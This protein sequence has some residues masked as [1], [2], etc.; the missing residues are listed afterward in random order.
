VARRLGVPFV[1]SDHVTEHRSGCAIREFFARKGEGRFRDVE[2]QV[3]DN[4]SR[5]HQGVIATDGGA[6]LPEANCQH[7]HEQRQVIYLRSKPE[8]FFRPVRLDYVRPLLLVDDPLKRLRDFYDIRD[9]LYPEIAH[10]VWRPEDLR[11]P[12]WSI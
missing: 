5:T 3:L 6:V 2:Q 1:D 12:L 7:L 10:F 11:W 8:D 4:V 9:P